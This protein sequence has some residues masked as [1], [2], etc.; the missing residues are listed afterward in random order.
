[1]LVGPTTINEL[2]YCHTR[3]MHS[4][5]FVGRETMMN[6]FHDAF[7]KFNQ[8]TLVVESLSITT[9]L[10]TVQFTIHEFEDGYI[11]DHHEYEIIL[12]AITQ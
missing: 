1:M 2:S 12:E 11:G 10:N 9:L 7:C 4:E 8:V 5:R 6:S 3:K